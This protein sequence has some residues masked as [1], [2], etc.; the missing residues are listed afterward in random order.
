[1]KAVLLRGGGEKYIIIGNFLPDS[2]TDTLRFQS[3]S[4]YP[5]KVASYYLID[6]IS[7]ECCDPLGCGLTIPNGITP[8]GDGYNETWKIEGLVPGV[9]VQVFNRWGNLVFRAI[10]TTAPGMAAACPTARIIT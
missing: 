9:K 10:H 5:F 1:L 6:N 8:N 3:Q 4:Q 2:L 7:V